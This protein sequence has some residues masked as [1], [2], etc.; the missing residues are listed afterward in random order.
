[1][2]NYDDLIITRP[3]ADFTM[4]LG[5][6]LGYGFD[7]DEALHLDSAHYDI[8]DENYRP[9]LN[10][11]I[12]A[13]FALRE[14][15]QE[16]GEQFAFMLGRKMNEIMPLYNNLYLSTK[17]KFN[18]LLTQDVTSVMDNETTNQSSGKTSSTT[19]SNADTK[20]STTTH[21]K[22][23]NMAAHSELPQTRVDD[24]DAYVNAADK[25][26]ST[27]D[28]TVNGD[29]AST[30]HSEAQTDNQF[31][32]ENGKGTNTTHSSGFSGVSGA[33]LIMQYRQ[34]LINVDL[35]IFDELET[36][37]MGIWGAPQPMSR[38]RGPIFN[39]ISM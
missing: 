37:F 7:T 9:V 20:S 19:D 18:P 32:S 34:A 11:K 24:F 33:Q 26:S 29:Q 38:R 2:T 4:Q 35:M 3:H 10:H 14:I 21:S 8:F 30:S 1:M 23:E 5:F 31:T 12:V 27:S 15:G 6:L 16:T 25:G 39:D 36:L 17:M 22:S 13:H 28:S